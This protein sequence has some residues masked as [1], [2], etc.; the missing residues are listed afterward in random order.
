MITII[1]T[2]INIPTQIPALKMSPITSH[3]FRENK[4]KRLRR[5]R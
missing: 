2:T 4:N 3:E 1:T 5:N